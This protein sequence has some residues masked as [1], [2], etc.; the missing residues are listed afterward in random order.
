MNILPP[1]PPPLGT[2]IV[3]GAHK[4]GTTSLYALLARHP[5]ISMSVV[6]ETNRYCPDLWPLLPHLKQ[7]TAAEIECLHERGETRHLGLIQD[8]ATY[9]R[10]F[11]LRPG[12]R[13]RGEASPFYLRSTRAAQ[14][15]ARHHPD[16][17]I[18]VILRDPIE[19]LYSH[20]AMEVRDARIPE[21]IERAIREEQAEIG[22]EKKSLHGLLDSGCYGEGLSRFYAH[23]PADQILCMDISELSPPEDVILRIASFLDIDP[24][25]FASLVPNQNES[26]SARNPRLNRLLAQTGLKGWVR[27]W[28]PQTIIDALK[29]LYYRPEAR[30]HRM[31]EDLHRELVAYYQKDMKQLETLIGPQPWKWLKQYADDAIPNFRSGKFG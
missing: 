21:P 2:V 28:V 26:V 14:E 18:I 31:T 23:F 24:L 17:R 7:L 10:L 3:A 27:A 29:P 11:A 15:I 6:K 30:K 1:N 8:E 22:K 4:A 5:E 12:L 13:Y 16:A 25:G 9:T 20:Y 19:R